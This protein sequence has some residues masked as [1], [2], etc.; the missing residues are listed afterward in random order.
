[1]KES[2]E[3]GEV[4]TEET[5]D[6]EKVISMEDPSEDTTAKKTK[7]VEWWNERRTGDMTET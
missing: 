2:V 1:M 7:R 5:A 6:G 3:G 4:T